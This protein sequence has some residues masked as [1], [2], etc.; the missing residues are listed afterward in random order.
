VFAIVVSH[1]LAERHLYVL[2]GNEIDLKHDLL[3]VA[4]L[5]L[6]KTGHAVA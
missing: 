3:V 4:L 1:N 2:H 5:T 6:Q